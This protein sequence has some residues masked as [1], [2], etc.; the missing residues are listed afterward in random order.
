MVREHPCKDYLFY[1]LLYQGVSNMSDKVEEK[2]GFTNRKDAYYMILE[3][4]LL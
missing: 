1:K 2:N 4:T 3:R